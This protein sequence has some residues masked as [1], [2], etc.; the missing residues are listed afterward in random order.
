MNRFLAVPAIVASLTSILAQSAPGD[1]GPSVEVR[2]DARP[3]DDPVQVQV[4]VEDAGVPATRLSAGD[5]A[6]MLDGRPVSDFDLTRPRSQGADLKESIAFVTGGLGFSTASGYAALI[7][8]LAVGDHAAIVNYRLR[9][10]SEGTVVYRSIM[11]FTEIDGA[12]NTDA[13]INFLASDPAY[14]TTWHCCQPMSPMAFDA[15]NQFEAPPSPLPAGL[16]VLVGGS[17]VGRNALGL[18]IDRAIASDVAV[19]D[20]ANQHESASKIVTKRLAA[21]ETGGALLVISDD[22]QYADAIARI[23][24]WLNDSYRLSISA[25]VA[26]CNLHALEVT[27]RGQSI[28]VSFARCDSTPDSFDLGFADEVESGSRIV[29]QPVTI[30]GIE[31]PVAVEVL[32][33]EYSIGC[34]STFTRESGYVQPLETVCVRHTASQL[35][36]DLT[37]TVLIV[38]GGWATFE[39]QTSFAPPPPVD[40]NNSGGGGLAGAAELLV[41]LGLLLARP[42]GRPVSVGRT[43]TDLRRIP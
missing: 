26:D 36:N 7:H 21:R 12:A 18:L 34:G 25:A 42:C 38:G 16:R 13:A 37:E 11:P 29:S 14:F 41:L 3:K 28:A 17:D 23:G 20:V 6:V 35:P 31:S 2:I 22:S 15:L 24:A 32:G 43:C 8:R 39:S 1:L 33:G 5:F 4:L 10:I 27:V 9:P 40:D 30:T 19:F